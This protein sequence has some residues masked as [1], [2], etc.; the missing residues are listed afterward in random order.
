M[1]FS[2]Q[3]LPILQNNGELRPNCN[4]C[5][6]PSERCDKKKNLLF[7]SLKKNPKERPLLSTLL[8]HAFIKKAKA[9][10]SLNFANWVK[11]QLGKAV[12]LDRR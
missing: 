4:F 5:L 3:N 12:P 7:F 2:R 1:V 9:D 10:E 11:E 8:D 6:S